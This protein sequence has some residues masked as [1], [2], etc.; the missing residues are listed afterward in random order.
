MMRLFLIEKHGGRRIDLGLFKFNDEANCI[1]AAR[2][3]HRFIDRLETNDF[4]FE[5]LT[6]PGP[7]RREKSKQQ[8]PEQLVID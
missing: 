1:N 7:L 6:E 2:R 4:E 8:R 5:G 3:K